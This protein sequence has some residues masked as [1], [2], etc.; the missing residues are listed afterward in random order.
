MSVAE[1]RPI[2]GIDAAAIKLTDRLLGYD[3]RDLADILREIA[4]NIGVKHIAYLRFSA[5]NS[6]DVSLLTAV[7]TYSREWQTRYFLRK[8][9]A[10]DPVVTHGSRAVLPFDWE[11][12]EMPTPAV[13]SF[14]ADALNHGVG[15]RGV[16]IPVRNRRNACALVSLNGD[17]DK[18]KWEEFKR[19][20]MVKLQILSAL[21]NSAAGIN[22]KLLS[23]PVQLSKREEQC[24]VWAARGK[25]YQEVAEILNISF[26][27]VK[28]HLDTA[29]H[30]L[31]CMNLTHAVAVAIATEVIPAQAL[32]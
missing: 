22:S 31:H 2:I 27:S 3:D 7:V 6:V 1:M 14:F 19:E 23:A 21:I 17:H 15:L 20:N 29:R 32:K 9:S 30:K 8:Y 18:A 24:L 13:A 25:T 16:S 12:F 4:A 5:E 11:D 28:T 10:I 26:G